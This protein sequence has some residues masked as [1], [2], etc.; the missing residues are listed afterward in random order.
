MDIISVMSDMPSQ[1]V[2]D[3]PSFAKSR[4]LSVTPC[5]SSDR[6]LIITYSSKVV[7]VRVSRQRPLQ[8]HTQAILSIPSSVAMIQT[9]RGIFRQPSLRLSRETGSMISSALRFGLLDPIF[10]VFNSPSQL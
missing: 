7:Y 6:C 10:S 3:P 5:R 8:T 9:L 2:Q 4:R 1:E